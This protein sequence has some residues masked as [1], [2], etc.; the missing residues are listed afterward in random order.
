MASC[1]DQD[2]CKT[3][4]LERHQCRMLWVVL[5]LNVAMICAGFVAGQLSKVD[6][7]FVRHVCRC[8]WRSAAGMSLILVAVIRHCQL[9]GAMQPDGLALPKSV[10]PKGG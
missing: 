6:S 4:T 2:L 10:S 3:Q 5:C 7:R 1:C 8:R 9:G